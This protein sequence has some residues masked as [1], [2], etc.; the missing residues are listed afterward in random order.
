MIKSILSLIAALVLFSP[1]ANSQVWWD[2]SFFNFYSPD[3]IPATVTSS[4][5]T[6]PT[7]Q[8][9]AGHESHTWW[10]RF[11]LYAPNITFYNNPWNEPNA[12]YSQ[13]SGRLLKFFSPKTQIDTYKAKYSWV[14][15]NYLFLDG[16]YIGGYDHY[17]VVP[18]NTNL[19]NIT[20]EGERFTSPEELER[21]AESITADPIHTGS[22]NQ[23]IPIPVITLPGELGADVTYIGRSK[24]GDWVSEWTPTFAAAGTLRALS[25]SGTTRFLE[26]E[27]WSGTGP[28]RWTFGPSEKGNHTG[29]VEETLSGTTV[30]GYTYFPGNG[31][32]KNFATNGRVSSHE[33]LGRKTIVNLNSGGVINGLV[34]LSTGNWISFFA[35]NMQDKSAT[36]FAKF[37]VA[38][39]YNQIQ[40][41]SG[42]SLEIYTTGGV[43][44]WMK[45]PSGNYL[46]QNT[47]IGTR[48][49]TQTDGEG[50]IWEFDYENIE[51]SGKL[52]LQTIET[53]P[54]GGEWGYIHDEA[55]LLSTKESPLGNRIEIDYNTL[56]LRE[57]VR[58]ARNN[59][60]NFGYNT[61]RLPTS[62]TDEDGNEW[63]T[64][65]NATLNV[66]ATE[67]PL[68]NR[69]ET[70]YGSDNTITSI[71]NEL[72]NTW[73]FLYNGTGQLTTTT[74]PNYSTDTTTYTAGYPTSFISRAGN[75]WTKSFNTAGFLWKV[76][77]PITK[78]T[79]YTY[80]GMGRITKVKTPL[81]Y[82]TETTYNWAG[83][84]ITQEDAA[85][86]TT[87]TVYDLNQRMT[88]V[89]DRLG[90]TTNLEYDGNGNLVLITDAEGRE[91]A[92]G[93]DLDDRLI[94]KS[95]GIETWGYVPDPNGNTSQ[96]IRPDTTIEWTL[97]HNPRNLVSS[98]TDTANFTWNQEYDE[99]G[100]LEEIEDPLTH[101][102]TFNYNDRGDLLSVEDPLSLTASQT[103]NWEGNITS[104]TDAEGHITDYTFNTAG[105]LTGWE[106]PN[107]KTYALTYN[108]RELVHT[109]TDPKSQVSTLG[110]DDD[111]RLV[112][113]T[114][115]VGTTSYTRD[116]LGRITTLGTT[117]S[118]AATYGYDYE[119]RITS[120]TGE[121]SQ[122]VGYTYDDTGKVETLVYGG[123]TVTYTYDSAGRMATITDWNS[124]VTTYTYNTNGQLWKTELPNGTL[125]TRT[126]N[127]RDLLESIVHSNSG[128]PF[129]SQTLTYDG[130]RRITGETITDGSGTQSRVFTYDDIGRMLSGT[131]T[132]LGAYSATYD[133]ATNITQI[134]DTNGTLDF[135]FN[136]D[137]EI[138]TVN[139]TS[140][141]Y[142]DNGNLTYG[143]RGS[144]PPS[145]S[146]VT[147]SWDAR[148]RLTSV[149]TTSYAYDSE[150]RRI[151]RTENSTDTT[152]YVYEPATNA[153]LV[154]INPDGSK[155]LYVQGLG[156]AYS[157]QLDNT[158]SE[159]GVTYHH[160]DSRGSTV[161][162]TNGAATLTGACN[163]GPYGEEVG[164]T[165]PTTLRF[166][167]RWG[168]QTDP[169]GLLFLQSR[170]YHPILKRFI[171]SDTIA[172]SIVDHRTLNT[173]AYCLGNPIGYIDPMGTEPLGGILGWVHMGLDGAGMFP[174]L[175]LFP[176]LL[177]AAIYLGE[178]D[179]ASMGFSLGAAIPII[180]D[181]AMASKY[182]AKGIKAI[183]GLRKAE[184]VITI[185]SP[186]RNLR[187]IATGAE[188]LNTNQTKVLSQLSEY[189]KSTTVPKKTFGQ[190]DLA[191]ISAATGD[192]FAMFTTGGQRMIMRGNA[193]S[194]PIT[195]AKAQELSSKGW[196]WSSHTH[197]DGVMRSSSGDQKVLSQFKNQRSAI[198]DTTG[199][200]TSFTKE[201]DQISPT[202]LP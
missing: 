31:K 27:T 35:G 158:G 65:Y 55:L 85:N 125:E 87:S 93:Y 170:F 91:T 43:T 129:W 14:D 26:Q 106:S 166:C 54:E 149:D 28:K 70:I 117:G 62:Y 4:V 68:G 133:D 2:Q 23:I 186:A 36:R 132:P 183:K 185:S 134:V 120:Y 84:P 141:L 58:D 89:T 201:G 104:V 202:W 90:K 25:I 60:Q 59:T 92:F 191:A 168:V 99:R 153:I 142:D 34:D 57:E 135:I 178:G 81:G 8:W 64:E 138:S 17:Q 18:R 114:D 77:N 169:N 199:K 177:N 82:E 3:Y 73:S 69:V 164:N 113:V 15:A 175:G 128:T 21:Q 44:L 187:A 52:Y 189:G 100:L 6:G 97:T 148:D 11:K 150:N 162:T 136:T 101:V 112:T 126:Y 48:I 160:Y 200:R 66:T 74:Y 109:I 167:G 163:Y 196:R 176:D 45:D 71:T 155:S 143:P 193:T 179:Y 102:W 110:Y 86:Q 13:N 42:Q 22:G 119:G 180:G 124:R 131:N 171:S 63:L 61:Y 5:I 29:Y 127:S 53:R 174:G 1:T 39:T 95:N 105:Q 198:L 182:A 40:L 9:S 111:S 67:D 38:P 72:N 123:K 30:T 49:A 24:T 140:V 96:I 32:R 116:A 145:S 152:S 115:P 41:A 139:S 46:F 146:F 16:G 78:T 151:T 157:V 10:T 190:T 130:A 83:N 144:G 194:V 88:S 37:R 188:T 154:Q 173:Y 165:L 197:P 156:L 56:G 94:S 19:Y 147:Y 159:T 75:T 161:V 184:E 20:G 12:G 172:G 195:P 118:S 108:S 122:T 7:L 51:D 33:E 192:E 181:A 47:F 79:E 76:T 121:N 103:I 50:N 107:G 137:N 80:D 98:K